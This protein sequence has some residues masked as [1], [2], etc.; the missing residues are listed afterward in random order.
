MEFCGTARVVGSATCNPAF[1]GLTQKSERAPKINDRPAK[2]RLM[3]YPIAANSIIMNAGEAMKQLL[4]LAACLCAV[5]PD[6]TLLE[7]LRED[8]HC[9]AVKEGCASGELRRLH[10]HAR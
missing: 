2:C 6:R 8:L 10:R 4:V 7:L 3:E 1:A 9:T 5:P